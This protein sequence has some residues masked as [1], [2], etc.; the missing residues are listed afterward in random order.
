MVKI[1]FVNNPPYITYGI[2]AGLAQIG[3]EPYILPLWM[4]PWDEQAKV[5]RQKI[6]EIS[7]DFIFADGDPPNVNWEA[8]SENVRFFNVPLIYWA[9][10][11]PLWFKEISLLRSLD[12][13]FVCTTTCELIPEYQKMGKKAALML[14]CCNPDFHRMVESN[15]EYR[16]DIMF[17]GSNYEIRTWVSR[18]M[19]QPL[20]EKGY[21]LKVWGH[22][23]RD[24][25]KPFTIPPEFY[26]GLLPYD[27]LPEAYASAR[28]ILG[29]HLCD[30]SLTQTS[31]R[32]YEVLGCGSFYL[33]QYTKAHE[34]LFK[35][36]VHLDWAN[37]SEELVE[38]VDYYLSCPEERSKIAKAGQEYVY[39]YH[40]AEVRARRL[41]EFLST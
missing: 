22:W 3:E 30:T 24:S 31:M 26:K 8:I 29:M 7:P 2:A 35:R 27:K 13:E 37:N 41:V 9:T 23:W 6:E 25:D 39:K 32:T 17:V 38:K 5:L 21:N 11:D 4:Y 40:S 18:F 20:L 12:A 19:L 15:P 34:H 33:T 10:E 1:L 16:C 28:I 14:F 36:G